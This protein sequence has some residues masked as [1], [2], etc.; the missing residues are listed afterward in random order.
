MT[1]SLRK[2]NRNN[3]LRKV[4]SKTLFLDD[5]MAKVD[6]MS[7]FAG[8]F[9]KDPPF[10]KLREVYRKNEPK[11]PFKMCVFSLSR[12]LTGVKHSFS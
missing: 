3:I 6:K 9:K 2:T 8:G 11:S 4:C 5:R 1:I 7:L 10:Y 12:G